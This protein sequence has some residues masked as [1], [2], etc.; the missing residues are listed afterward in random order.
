M[1][2]RDSTYTVSEL[3]GGDTIDGVLYD[4]NAYDVTVTL[5]D[6]GKGHIDAQVGYPAGSENGLAFEN[7][8]TGSD[9]TSQVIA[10]G[11]T[12]VGRDMAAGEFSFELHAYDPT[13]GTMGDKVASTTNDA[14][15]NGVRGNVAFGA[16][17]YTADMLDGAASKT[18]YY[19]VTEVEGTDDNITYNQNGN[20]FYAGVTVTN[21]GQGNLTSTTTYYTDAT[22]MTAI[23]DASQAPCF[24]NVY[25]PDP[26]AVPVE[27]T[28][29][30]S[31]VEAAPLPENLTFGYE[32][33]NVND[34]NERYVGTSPANGSLNA[35]VTVKGTGTFT[36]RITAGNGGPTTGGITYD[37]SVYYLVL[38]VTTDPST[39][40]YIIGKQYYLGDPNNG[41]TP[42]DAVSFSNVYGDEVG[43]TLDLSATKTLSG[44]SFE[45]LNPFG[46]TVTETTD[47]MD[48][49]V[50]TGTTN[51]A[52]GTAA[53][54]DLSTISY[55]FRVEQPDEPV[56]DEGTTTPD[57]QQPTEGETTE[58]E[59]GTEGTTPDQPAEGTEPGADQ[60][61]TETGTETGGATE[62]EQPSGG[63]GE[64]TQPEQ[65]A[66]GE[67]TE[68]GGAGEVVEPPAAGGETGEVVEPVEPVVPETPVE[69]TPAQP[70]VT[71]EPAAPEAPAEGDVAAASITDLFVASEAIADDVDAEVYTGAVV[72]ETAAAAAD[73]TAPVIDETAP[74][75]SETAPAAETETAPAAALEPRVVSSDLG[76]HTYVISENIPSGAVQ[77][78]DGTYTYEGVTYDSHS[79]VVTVD[80]QAPYDAATQTVTMTATIKSID[81]Y[82]VFGNVIPETVAGSDGCDNVTFANSYYASTPAKLGGTDIQASKTLTGR[83]MADKEFS[84]TIAAAA[85]NPDGTTA[86]TTVAVGTSTAAKANEASAISFGELTFSKPGTYY[87]SLTEDNAG[88]TVN[89]VT[90][91]TAA[92]EFSVTV[93]DNYD[94]TLSATVNYPEGGMAFTNAYK[95]NTSTSVTFAGTK[96]LVGR[97]MADKEFSF[98][99]TELMP[100]GTSELVAGGQNA[101]AG[102][103]EA[104][105]IT[106]A[107]IK[108]TEPGE[109]DYVIA[110]VN[111]GTEKDGVTYDA[112][113]FNA[114]VSVTDNL[115]GT[116]STAV[117]YSVGDVPCDAIAFENVYSNDGATATVTP[118]ASK[119]LTGRDM[120]DGEFAF[121]VTDQATGKVV[122]NGRNAAD[123]T[124]AF[125]AITLTT[126][127]DYEFVISEVNNR[128]DGVTYDDAT[129]RMLVSATD[130]GK[131]GL[132]AEMSYP[133]GKPAFANSYKEPEKPKPA[134]PQVP[135]TGDDGMNFAG[136]AALGLG[137][138]GAALLGGGALLRRRASR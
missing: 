45:Q 135:K 36:S 63:E 125:D 57:E 51:G 130:D 93:T 117:T 31:T 124:V 21:D 121:V 18:F 89:G 11:K 138:L 17:S 29:T 15:A 129:F 12:L 61:G 25:T 73:E 137:G 97:D 55:S 76:L 42:V 22:C 98:T 62:P 47:G 77:N 67:T 100:D 30:T 112:T 1:C 41:G 26:I 90:Y 14:A 43:A 91:S 56:V 69:E 95:V 96:T 53:E 114:H 60:P 58:G 13:T 127:G 119:T 10:V 115:D 54:V 111:G 81:C 33:V 3:D 128:Q 118:E 107:P 52:T 66:E 83:D 84:F 126:E 131:G 20:V 27:G 46:F 104:S 75:V 7:T 50:A 122:S 19:A 49:V 4:G 16:L 79:Y 134:E 105:D 28:K 82:D 59:Q 74:V 72:D 99:V 106:F 5:T 88:D 86:G 68:P 8:Y 44:A 70:E 23:E 37:D 87:F 94:G 103:R 123:G 2:I 24:V 132:S 101:A 6:D 110:E 108:Y 120:K 78:D 35:S 48:K 65:P 9:V 40:A 133:D 64:T 102:D 136:A 92:F 71:E 80:V 113:V 34:S 32:I 38:D 39:G 109:H 85:D 116:M